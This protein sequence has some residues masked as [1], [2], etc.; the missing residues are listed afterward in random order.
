MHEHC[1]SSF[2]I[3]IKRNLSRMNSFV[4]YHANN[5][6]SLL[7]KLRKPFFYKSSYILIYIPVCFSKFITQS[8][9]CKT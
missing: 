4:S 5:I 6:Q 9:Y 1:C 7:H 8:I 3:Y 2:I